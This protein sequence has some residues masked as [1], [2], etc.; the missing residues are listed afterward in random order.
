MMWAAG[1]VRFVLPL[2]MLVS[3]ATSAVAAEP[4][5]D[6]SASDWLRWVQSQSRAFDE[7]M[8]SS[9]LA[10]TIHADSPSMIDLDG[11]VNADGSL[12]VAF[13]TPE[14]SFDVRCIDDHTCW[15][16]EHAS[17]RD[18]LW[19]R[20]SARELEGL[21]ETATELD[22][23]IGPGVSCSID[24]AAG[25]L[26]YDRDGTVIKASVSFAGRAFTLIESLSIPSD[27]VTLT[28]SKSLT[29]TKPVP[30][31]RPR[32]TSVGPPMITDVVPE[33]P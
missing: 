2:I 23:L 21:R 26:D 20:V 30:V 10:V 25:L 31:Q 18:A 8:A 14:A 1:T 29:R 9:A 19:H 16:H 12:H 7:R 33:L 15:L 13:S 17:G 3:P 4:S 28:V 6:V 5:R 27:D 11:V 22:G 32:V 24:G